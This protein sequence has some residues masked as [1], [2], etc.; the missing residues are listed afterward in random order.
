MHP[1]E[2]LQEYLELVS[3]EFRD[4]RIFVSGFPY[5]LSNLTIPS[6]ITWIQSP[7]DFEKMLA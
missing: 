2:Q 3:D 7:D 5:I 6:N 1:L 4:L